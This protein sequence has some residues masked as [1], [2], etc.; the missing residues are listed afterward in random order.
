MANFCSKCGNQ[1]RPEANFCNRCGNRVIP[2]TPDN[3][4]QANEKIE[5]NKEELEQ[6]VYEKNQKLYEEACANF[7]TSNYII[8]KDIFLKIIDY[9]DSKEKIKECEKEIEKAENE[10][11]EK[12]ELEKKQEMYD[13]ACAKMKGD[14]NSI[15]EAISIFDCI[16]TFKDAK[17]KIKDCQN[18]VKKMDEEK[19]EETYK[20]ACNLMKNNFE[21]FE[22]KSFTDKY[23]MTNIALKNNN[24]AL[25]SF[26]SIQ[27]YKDSEDKIKECEKEIEKFQALKKQYNQKIRFVSLTLVLLCLIGYWVFALI[28][29]V[30][31][32]Y[33]FDNIIAKGDYGLIYNL[34]YNHDFLEYS[35]DEQCRK[36]VDY[37]ITNTKNIEL[38]SVSGFYVDHLLTN[39]KK[40]NLIALYEMF[41]NPT[42]KKIN[43]ETLGQKN[44]NSII[45]S[46]YPDNDVE[47]RYYLLENHNFDKFGNKSIAEEQLKIIAQNVNSNSIASKYEFLDKSCFKKYGNEILGKTVTDSIYSSVAGSGIDEKLK[48]LSNQSTKPYLAEVHRKE[49]INSLFKILGYLNVSQ[50][51]KFLLEVCN[52]DD[53]YKIK[54][55]GDS[56]PQ[57]YCNWLIERTLANNKSQNLTILNGFIENN[58]T[59]KNIIALK[60]SDLLKSNINSEDYKPD[61][62]EAI[63]NTYPWVFNL[64]IKDLI[65]KWKSAKEGIKKAENEY[66]YGGYSRIERLKKER[67]ELPDIY[68][69]TGYI[70]EYINSYRL[71]DG[72]PSELYLISS[73]YHGSSFLFTTKTSY[74]TKGRFV[75]RAQKMNDIPSN[76]KSYFSS[77]YNINAY[78]IEMSE[79]DYNRANSK[80]KE[81]SEEIIKLEKEAKERENTKV[82][83]KEYLRTIKNDLLNKIYEEINMKLAAESLIKITGIEMVVCPSGSFMMGSSDKELGRDNDERPH[84]V[85]ISKTFYIGKYEVTQ[86]QYK[87]LMGNNPSQSYG[88]NE[89]VESVSWGNAI[90]FCDKLNSKYGNYL[91]KGYK[92][93]LPTEAQ[94]EYACRAGTTTALNNGK[95]LTS[96]GGNYNKDLN[97]DEVAWYEKNSSQTYHEVGKKKPNSWGI[98]DMH[99][100]VYEWCRDYYD[101]YSTSSVDPIC[102]R[103]SLRIAR[104]GYFGSEAKK[105]RSAYRGKFALN[106]KLSIG[107]R[108]ALVPE[109]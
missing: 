1:L 43:D 106:Y 64:E 4:I 68:Q 57:S 60:A 37:L 53:L 82:K 27:N 44:I 2:S 46:F 102:S 26:N 95:N 81:L 33:E 107:F 67:S 41:D 62:I 65:D 3:S 9:K 24:E 14:R 34:S 22:K 71:G 96:S 45:S 19:N 28:K 93:D 52:K 23:L 105:C 25:N 7:Y 48:L 17:D 61:D 30:Y 50:L 11:R 29:T 91:P 97:L 6:Q 39:T 88:D 76:L 56:L 74:S 20:N 12:R 21:D 94:W 84:K 55:I 31:Y 85:T 18:I 32:R 13:K 69:L 51:D 73:D 92:F 103:G 100:N 59:A 83:A 80:Y 87:S 72:T 58:E 109:D 35:S 10:K 63:V 47:N 66:A 104:G 79:Y 89:P 38:G 98:H 42:F 36:V 77:K 75:L 8:A 99:G 15:I 108:I 70:V 16:K 54:E 5:E 78:Y 40:D 49:L 90:E 86:K 101:I